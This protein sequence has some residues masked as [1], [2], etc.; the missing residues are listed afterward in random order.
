MPTK[1]VNTGNLQRHNTV[2][3]TRNITQRKADLLGKKGAEQLF[4]GPEL[5]LAPS[6]CKNSHDV[7]LELNK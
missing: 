7:M 1:A 6:C 2:L 5:T 4:T 3:D